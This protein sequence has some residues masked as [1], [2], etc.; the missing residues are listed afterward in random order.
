[1]NTRQAKKIIAE[2]IRGRY[3]KSWKRSTLLLAAAIVY[4]SRNAHGAVGT[5]LFMRATGKI[6]ETMESFRRLAKAFDAVSS[7]L[8]KFS[9]ETNAELSA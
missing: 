1:M 6:N 8:A 2:L 5:I 3:Y 9:R 7:A 4:G